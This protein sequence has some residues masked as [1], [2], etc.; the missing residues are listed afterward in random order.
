VTGT[1]R[2]LL[3][4]LGVF[5]LAWLGLAI[6]VLVVRVAHDAARSALRR[7]HALVIRAGERDLQTVGRLMRWLPRRL[8]ERAVADPATPARLSE[9]F[10]AHVLEWYPAQVIRDAGTAT[11]RKR[12]RRV[13]ALKILT[14]ARWN[15]AVELLEDAL[16]TDEEELVAAAVAMLGALGDPRSS[17]LLVRTLRN[18]AFA[19]SRVA[20]Q[21]DESHQPIAHL[22]VPLLRDTDA[23]VRY[24][25]VTLLAR[26]A[27]HPGVDLE[28]T[29]CAT[30]TE[31]SVR[32]AAVASLAG[33]GAPAAQLT[34][35]ALLQDPVWFVRAHAA[36]ALRD[37]EGNNGPAVAP[38]LAD[39]SWWV[40]AAA[41]E[42]LEARPGLAL[43]LLL[44]YLEHEDGFARN[45]AAE[46]LQNT[47]VLDSLLGEESEVEAHGPFPT[48][49]QRILAAG[50]SRLASTAAA[51]NGL[52]PE[53]MEQLAAAGQ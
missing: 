6:Y 33:R 18:N 13:R 3:P 36:R 45:G 4:V 21:L 12:W 28:L 31:P 22:L 17:R 7:I 23:Q 43:E 30:D 32:A 42:T 29:R 2:Y 40:R 37:L 48:T 38:L 49:A 41:K 1:E 16:A 10:A 9:L 39:E 53:Y 51:R 44:G 15:V 14:I 47:G 52:D 8:L 34:A 26:Y 11:A 27:G 25:A 46:V 19:R 35:V 50:G 24:W 5:A 20:S